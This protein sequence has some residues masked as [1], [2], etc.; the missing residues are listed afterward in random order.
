MGHATLL[1]I[2]SS[3]CSAK[4][5]QPYCKSAKAKQSNFA[6]L[7]SARGHP[8][9]HIDAPHQVLMEHRSGGTDKWEARMKLP[10]ASMVSW[11]STILV[12]YFNKVEAR[13]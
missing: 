12:I 8:K 2:C 7:I 6:K 13:A 9:R 4:K 11:L 5:D 1:L 10:T 3:V